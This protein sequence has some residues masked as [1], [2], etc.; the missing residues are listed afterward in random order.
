[1]DK[2]KIKK[3]SYSVTWFSTLDIRNIYGFIFGWKRDYLS[4]DNLCDQLKNGKSFIRWGDGETANLRG[5]STWH[6][7]GNLQLSESLK[8]LIE[9]IQNNEDIVVFG[10]PKRAIE[11]SLLC[12]SEWP[13]WLLK[14]LWSTRILFNSR[15]FR[16]LALRKVADAEIWY[17]NFKLLP[18]VFSEVLKIENRDVGLVCSN[19][20]EKLFGETQSFKH[21]EILPRNAFDD[22]SVLREKVKNW[23]FECS[24]SPILFLAG[25]SASKLLISENFPSLQIIDIGSGLKALDHGKITRDWL[26]EETG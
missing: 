2:S 9:Y 17:T 21:F 19:N 24:N 23:T 20:F 11:G 25:G 3:F 10:I 12:R 7:L 5:K 22:Y 18:W 6:Q 8:R 4:F 1:M 16:A 15:G 26:S 14:I 13:T